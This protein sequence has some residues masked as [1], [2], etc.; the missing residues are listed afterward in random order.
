MWYTILNN[1]LASHEGLRC[2]FLP[3]NFPWK[4]VLPMDITDTLTLMISFGVLIVLIMSEN[5]K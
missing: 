2:T 4:G 5:K 1:R 3:G